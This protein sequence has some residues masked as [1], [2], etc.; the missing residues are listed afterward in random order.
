MREDEVATE[1]TENQ[2]ESRFNDRVEDFSERPEQ[3]ENTDEEEEGSLPIPAPKVEHVITE[4]AWIPPWD[5]TAALNSLKVHGSKF[6][7]I[8]P[9]WYSVNPDGTLVDRRDKNSAQILANKGNAKV[10][11]SIAISNADI[12]HQIVVN[13][14]SLTTHVDSIHQE[15]INNGYDGIDIDYEMIYLKSGPQFKEFIER[16]TAKLNSSGK[17]LSLT[18]L[19]K[20]GDKVMYSAFPETREVQ[21]YAW[22]GRV[23]DEVRIMTY[24]YTSSGS[25]AAGPIAP[26]SWYEDV[27]EYSVT[28]I[29]K[30]KLVMGIHLYGYEWGDDGKVSAKT[31]SQAEALKIQAGYTYNHDL[32]YAEGRADY[33]CLRGGKCVLYF[34]DK[35]GVETR[36]ELAKK[37][38]IKGVVYWRLGGEGVLLD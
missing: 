26:I 5:T 14:T 18:L 17:I 3:N 29:P 37:Y 19:P 6:S 9:V 1:L 24:D 28:K 35:E 27:L 36:K 32:V 4:S 31:Y 33:Q 25:K 22:A 12:L 23:A 34:Q 30:E 21:D 16:L 8:S 11:P 7:T 15:V 20:W 10:L 2:I 38:N 13:P